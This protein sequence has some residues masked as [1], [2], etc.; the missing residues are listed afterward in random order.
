MHTSRCFVTKNARLLLMIACMIPGLLYAQGIIITSGANLVVNGNANLVINDGGFNNGGTFVPGTGTVTF[1]GT[2]SSSVTTIGGASTLNF[3]NLGFN[4]SAGGAKL[5]KSIAV[6]NNVIMQQ[7]TLDL[8]TFNLDLGTT[9]NISGE[10]AATSISGT[11]GGAVLRTVNLNAPTAF[12]PGNIGIEITSAANLGL[13]TIKRGHAQQVSASGYSI[14][15]Y[16]DITPANNT[17]LN[18]TVKFSYLDAE[19]GSVNE[20][21]LKLW[22]SANN[23]ATWALLG[24]DAQDATANYVLKNGVNQLNRL[25]LAS[26]VANPLPVSFISFTGQIIVNNVALKWVTGFESNNHHFEVERSFDGKNFSTIT[27]VQPS[28]NPAGAT[29]QHS[30][31]NPFSNGASVYYRIKQVGNDGKY[32]YSKVIYFTR[33]ALA[34]KFIGAYPNPTNGPL[35]L[36]FTSNGLIKTTVL[37]IFNNK[38]QLVEAKR[39]NVQAGLNDIQYNINHL[40]QGL[41]TIRLSGFGLNGIA[42]IKN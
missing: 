20:N 8:S 36:R 14:Y 27:E 18:A 2:A 42:I 7:G 25:T 26:S 24:A 41:Y 39:L 34:N 15:R 23:G 12:N 4:K 17:G 22:A 16:Y 35:Q 9:G 5:N 13:T 10:T 37:Q 6:A 11:A 32:A 38:G 31:V 28:G 40:A 3:Y 33:A 19:L 30:D 21:E 29:Y 1:T